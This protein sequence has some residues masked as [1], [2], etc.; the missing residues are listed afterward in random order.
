MVAWFERDDEA[1]VTWSDTGDFDGVRVG[2]LSGSLAGAREWLMTATIESTEFKQ[3][4]LGVK[5]RGQDRL[6]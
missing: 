5:L 2:C 3:G 1:A 4:Q 6:G